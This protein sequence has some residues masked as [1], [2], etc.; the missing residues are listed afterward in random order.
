MTK[1]VR[2]DAE[3]FLT[4]IR[5]ENFAVYRV[6]PTRLKEDVGQEAEIAHDYRGRLV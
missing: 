2:N 3:D 5:D 1:S 4:S 6:S